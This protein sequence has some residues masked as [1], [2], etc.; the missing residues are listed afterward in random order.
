L[1]ETPRI[2]TRVFFISLQNSVISTGLRL[3]RK[4]GLV[5]AKS[6]RVLQG[7]GNQWL[8]YLLPMVYD[9]GSLLKCEAFRGIRLS[10]YSG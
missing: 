10:G 7:L 3:A 5:E 4:R 9:L 6:W 8:V 2:T 1:I